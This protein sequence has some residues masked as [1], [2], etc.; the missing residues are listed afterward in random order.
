MKKIF[1]II[2]LAFCFQLQAKSQN[3]TLATIED[4]STAIRNLPASNI[5]YTQVQNM[6]MSML[7]SF[8]NR[9]DSVVY[10]TKTT[11]NNTQTNIDTLTVPNGEVGVFDLTITSQSGNNSGAGRKIVVVKNTSGTYSIV[12]QTELLQYK[13]QGTLANCS[14]VVQL[15]GG[16]VLVRVTGITGT[17]NWRVARYKAL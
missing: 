6:I 5:D 11:V 17:V 2:A 13:G 7:D 3:D 1:L 4:V 10:K 14:W 8:K 12:R 16:R 9:I 15:S